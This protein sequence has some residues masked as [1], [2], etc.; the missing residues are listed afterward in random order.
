MIW[1]GLEEAVGRSGWATAVT[2]TV[3][4]PRQSSGSNF[5]PADRCCRCNRGR[6]LL[7]TVLSFTIHWLTFYHSSKD[8]QSPLLFL[9]LN[10][11]LWFLLFPKRNLYFLG[12]QCQAIDGGNKGQPWK[13]E[14]RISIYNNLPNLWRITARPWRPL[15]WTQNM[16]SEFYKWIIAVS[17]VNL[18]ALF[19]T[20]LY[21]RGVPVLILFSEIVYL[22]ADTKNF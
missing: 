10:R 22:P 3:E 11:T 18:K 13:H 4:R 2:Q 16:V 1:I 21:F 14:R 15:I 20:F 19:D 5:H 8:A 9:L 6:P 7:L 12:L 17:T